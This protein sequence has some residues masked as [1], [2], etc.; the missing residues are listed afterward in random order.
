MIETLY[1]QKGYPFV[2][3]EGG[4]NS[5]CTRVRCRYNQFIHTDFHRKNDVEKRHK[6][7]RTKPRAMRVKNG[8]THVT[9][10]APS[11]TTRQSVIKALP[12]FVHESEL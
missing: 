8:T 12:L 1:A 7:T 11:D 10:T 2:D 3:I 4:K 5:R 6:I 9:S